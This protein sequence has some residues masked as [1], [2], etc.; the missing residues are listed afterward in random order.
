MSNPPPQDYLYPNTPPTEIG[1]YWLEWTPHNLLAAKCQ[2][3]YWWLPGIERKVPTQELVDSEWFRFGPKIELP[4]PPGTL[5]GPM[6]RT[7][8]PY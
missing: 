1:H 8:A 7:P 2:I 3:D 6:I 4:A 5:T